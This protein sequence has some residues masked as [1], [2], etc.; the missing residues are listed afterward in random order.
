M[1]IM[2][3]QQE[4]DEL[5]SQIPLDTPTRDAA[6]KLTDLLHDAI[7]A[8]RP[9]ARQRLNEAIHAGAAKAWR[10]HVQKQRPRARSKQGAVKSVGGVKRTVGA[11]VAFVQVPLEDMTH[12]ELLQYRG[13]YVGNL[14]TLGAN[15]RAVD[16]LLE[17]MG[18]CPGAKTAG[19]ACDRLG[20]EV[21]DVLAG[22]A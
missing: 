11:E 22:A 16:R 18:G 7:Q 17:I 20:I 6:A 10:S 2:T 3:E 19:E 5:L 9:W 4:W 1:T 12:A 13:M 14:S 21:G 8:Q 15:I